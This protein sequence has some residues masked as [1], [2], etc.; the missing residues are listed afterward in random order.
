MAKRTATNGRPFSPAQSPQR[1][2]RL[3]TAPPKEHPCSAPASWSAS[4][5]PALWPKT[6]LAN[7][8]G[9]GFSRA[10][11]TGERLTARARIRHEQTNHGCLGY[12]AEDVC[13]SGGGPPHSTTLVRSPHT[14]QSPIAPVR[15]RPRALRRDFEPA[16]AWRSAPQRTAAPSAPPKARNVP[17]VSARHHRRS[18]RK[19]RQRPGVRPALRRCGPRRSLP[20][21]GEMDFPA[22]R[23][24]AS[25]S[26]L[27]QEYG[28]SKRTMA[29][30]VTKRRRVPKRWRA[31]AL[32][33]AGAFALHLAIAKSL[34]SLPSIRVSSPKLGA[35]FSPVHPKRSNF[36]CKAES[37]LR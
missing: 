34:D 1:P 33:D 11:A 16:G 6:K 8:W 29:A 4:G 7:P 36:F 37:N 24:L 31:T 26:R 14:C 15:A 20:T 2:A 10:A 35:A 17:H 25:G 32:H 12:Q 3:S 18:G 28:T 27:A 9:N 21:R 22:P 23:L 19:A 30:W 13:Q 5:P